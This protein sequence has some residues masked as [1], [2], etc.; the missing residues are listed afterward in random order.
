MYY[1]KTKIGCKHAEIPLNDLSVHTRCPECG[2]EQ[3]VRF[4][5]LVEIINQLEGDFDADSSKLI[6]ER[7]SARTR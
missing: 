2:K 6:C 5:E 7:C 3:R 4:L 1:M